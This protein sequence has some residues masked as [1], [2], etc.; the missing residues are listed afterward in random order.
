MQVTPQMIAIV[1]P[2]VFLAAAIDAIGG[3]GGVIS[4]PAY[5]LAGLPWLYASG[6]N[7][8]TAGVGTLIATIRYLISGKVVLRPALVAVAGA[9]PGSYLGAELFKRVPEP[10]RNGFILVAIPLV[11]VFLLLHKNK[12]VKPRPMTARRYALCFLIGLGCGAYDGFFGPGTGTMLIMGLTYV[13][14]MD[15]VAASGSAKLINLASNLGAFAAM[16]RTGNVLFFLALPA[17]VCSVAGGYLGSW[18]AIRR[19]AGLIRYVMLGVLGFIMLQLV[20][21]LF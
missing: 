10:F 13:V 9:L 7:K 17:A 12:P 8:L 1:C 4:L 19:G 6:T 18:L 21:K 2:L 3:G 15:M 16:A 14:G 20:T 11:A 5:N